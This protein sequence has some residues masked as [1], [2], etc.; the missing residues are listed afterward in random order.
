MSKEQLSEVKKK[1]WNARRSKQSPAVKTRVLE[2]RAAGRYVTE[3]AREVGLAQNTVHVILN[4]PEAKQFE[5]QVHR[6]SMLGV[7][8]RDTLVLQLHG[9]ALLERDWR[10]VDKTERWMIA[11]GLIADARLPQQRVGPPPMSQQVHVLAGGVPANSNDGLQLGSYLEGSTMPEVLRLMDGIARDFPAKK[12][13]P[14]TLEAPAEPSAEVEQRK[15]AV[16]SASGNQAAV[17]ALRYRR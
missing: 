6:A 1:R 8:Q 12:A 17:P 4:E 16:A 10:L 2:L 3:I 15:E 5:E 13:G 7:A 14:P 11:R 9:R